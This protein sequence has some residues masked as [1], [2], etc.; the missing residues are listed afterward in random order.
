MRNAIR[1]GVGSLITTFFIVGCGS[2]VPQEAPPIRPAKLVQVEASGSVRKLSLPVVI[3]A[4]N[5]A[6][7]SFRVGGL[8]TELPIQS[9][10]QVKEGDVLARLDQ[11]D[12][13]NQVTQAQAQYDQAKSEFER[14]ERLVAENAISRSIYEQRKA[15]TDVASAALDTARKQLEDSVLRAPFD[16]VIANIPAIAMQN[17]APQQTILRLQSTGETQATARIPARLIANAGQF[18]PIAVEFTL[19][20]NP[21]QIIPATLASVEAEAD[22]ATQ[23][24][25]AYFNITPPEDA[26]ILPGMTG[27][28]NASLRDTILGAD[29][30][31]IRLPLEAILSAAGEQY[32]WVVDPESMRVSKQ[33]VSVADR[34]GEELPILAGLEGGELVVA[35]GGN[36]LHENMQ[37][38]RYQP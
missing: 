33:V 12:F 4:L 8:L 2:E 37:I 32:V 15:Q 20:S 36:Y 19:D 26:R 11:R 23:T 16:G 9:G 21:D 28:L 18:E 35:A 22:A 6:D 27:T 10:Q 5:S 38:R 7:I 17:V 3:Q 25:T 14:A 34:V 24:F 13:N 29:A 1:F 31:Q 30:A